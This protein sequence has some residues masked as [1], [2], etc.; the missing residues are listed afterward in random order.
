MG[1]G[2]SKTCSYCRND[3]AI[4]DCHQLIEHAK[5]ASYK[6]EDWAVRGQPAV[7]KSV[8]YRSV[9]SW[10]P[11]SD[12]TDRGYHKVGFD[13][14]SSVYRA[15][16]S[17]ICDDTSV[18]HAKALTQKQYDSLPDFM[19]SK[20]HSAVFQTSQSLSSVKHIVSLNRK[21]RAQA[22]SRANKACSYCRTSGHTVR[23]CKKVESDKRIHHTAFKISAYRYATALSRFGLWT[24]S[25]ALV[26]GKARMMDTVAFYPKLLAYDIKALRDSGVR[27]ADYNYS[28][29]DTDTFCKDN[30]MSIEDCEDFMFLRCALETG[31]KFDQLES[32]S[33]KEQYSPRLDKLQKADFDT[34][35]IRTREDVTIYKSSASLEHIYR[36]LV[37]RHKPTKRGDRYSRTNHVHY[38]SCIAGYISSTELFD[39]KKREDNAW[40]LVEAFIENNQDILNKIE[41]L[42]V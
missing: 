20:E 11:Q 30:N 37:E 22:Q 8:L 24:G 34:S 26:D 16:C 13:T 15:Q 7:D 10:Q 28:Y 19:E 9:Y 40:K 21:V 27:D 23:T 14:A 29:R 25:M 4:L 17:Y 18:G 3:H 36:I 5:Q 2:K 1:Y 38:P 31:L 39:K 41:T 33:W 42:S 12:G 32:T 6:L 35:S